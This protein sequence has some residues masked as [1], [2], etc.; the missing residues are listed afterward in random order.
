MNDSVLLT[1]DQIEFLFRRRK[2]MKIYGI[3]ISADNSGRLVVSEMP[4]SATL[5]HRPKSGRPAVWDFAFSGYPIYQKTGGI[6]DIVAF[7]FLIVR[8]KSSTRRVGQIL[9]AIHGNKEAQGVLKTAATKA[10]KAGGSVV[11][12]GQVVQLLVPVVGLVGEILTSTRDEVLQPISGAQFFDTSDLSEDEFSDSITTPDSNMRVKLDFVLFD[13][14]SGDDLTADTS[15]AE[16]VVTE[17][18]AITVH[19]VPKLEG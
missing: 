9:S 13:G 14:R 2:R 11:A 16:L 3:G 12:I 10:R 7:H 8:D 1:I 19:N 4:S 17:S 5:Y 6:P 15:G 18:G